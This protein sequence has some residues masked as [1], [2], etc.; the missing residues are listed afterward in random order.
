MRGVRGRCHACV[1]SVARTPDRRC[2]NL[3]RPYGL[4][5]SLAV[6]HCVTWETGHHHHRATAGMTEALRV[7]QWVGW[8]ERE[9]A[10]V[11]QVGGEVGGE[12]GGLYPM[13]APTIP[14]ESGERSH[15][16]P[17]GHAS[18][19]AFGH[20]SKGLASISCVAAGCHSWRTWSSV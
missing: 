11:S 1:W 12:V 5:F 7:V 9:A 10:R 4:T 8:I 20:L 13:N 16:Q 18:P 15:C 2:P 17:F 19:E 6:D 3:G 14:R